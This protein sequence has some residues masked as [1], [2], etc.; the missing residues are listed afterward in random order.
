MSRVDD[1]D[2]D[3]RVFF[4]GGRNNTY[5]QNGIII[6]RL[7]RFHCEVSMKDPLTL[8]S[9]RLELAVNDINF[10]NPAP[11]RVGKYL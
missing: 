11:F 8:N 4:Y 7:G 3:R 2:I 9:T 1:D 5:L 10:R 6:G